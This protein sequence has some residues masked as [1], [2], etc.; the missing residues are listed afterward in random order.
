[1]RYYPFLS[2]CAHDFRYIMCIRYTVY[3][4]YIRYTI[5]MCNLL[6][7]GR[8]TENSDIICKYAALQNYESSKSFYAVVACN[9]Y[10]VNYTTSYSEYYFTTFFLPCTGNERVIYI[11]SLSYYDITV[12][13]QLQ[14]HT[15][16]TT[17][18]CSKLAT[19]VVKRKTLKYF[20]C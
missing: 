19:S 18:R 17:R 2:F 6:Q 4:M 9:I 5:D 3:L 11:Q 8:D 20:S 12:H 15:F 10:T 7:V 1:M 16:Q 14:Y 13:T